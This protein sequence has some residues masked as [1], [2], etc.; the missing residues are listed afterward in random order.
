MDFLSVTIVL[1]SMFPLVVYKLTRKFIYLEILAV[2]AIFVYG[3]YFFGYKFIYL[4]IFTYII[5]TIV[6]LISLKTRFNFFGSKYHYRLGHKFFASGINYMNVYPLEV[7]LAWIIFKF[8]SFMITII[9]CDAFHLPNIFK[10]II[11]PLVLVSLDLIIDPLAVN[12]SGLWKWE[13]GDRY[14]GIPTG[15]FFGW[16]LVGLVSSVLFS[17]VGSN[18]SVSF[19][20]LHLLPIIFYASYIK[21]AGKLFKINRL[22]A[23]LGVI[24]VIVWSI[25]GFVGLIILYL[26]QFNASYR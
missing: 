18:F 9:I 19:H 25:L 12:I 8:L 20:T 15:N 13:K 21:W 17:L 6:E 5:S 26:N 2:P 3:V 16:M 4:I 10:I 1:L 23:I 14:F 22:Q 24:P 11:V 7:S